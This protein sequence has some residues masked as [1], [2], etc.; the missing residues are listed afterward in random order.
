MLE[1]DGQL[2]ALLAA[3]VDANAP[4]HGSLVSN[5]L[6]GHVRKTHVNGASVEQATAGSF[7][8]LSMTSGSFEYGNFLCLFGKLN[9]ISFFSQSRLISIEMLS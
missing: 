5:K 3:A 6:H 7:Q 9:F 8:V 4:F 2:A 1:S